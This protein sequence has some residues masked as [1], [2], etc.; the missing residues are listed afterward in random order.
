MHFAKVAGY[1]EIV[2]VAKMKSTRIFTSAWIC[3]LLA[4]SQTTTAFVQAQPVTGKDKDNEWHVLHASARRTNPIEKCMAEA[5]TITSK[6]WLWYTVM[7]SRNPILTKS[8]TASIL[9]SISDI[10]CQKLE[11]SS[12]VLVDKK[13]EA[14][15]SS[16]TTRIEKS[17]KKH[18]WKRTLDVA[19]VGL[20]WTGPATHAW[21]ATLERIV[22]TRHPI[23]GLA[24]RISLDAVIFAPI[25]GAY[26][27]KSL[28]HTFCCF[29][30][31]REL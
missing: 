31:F 1:F 24:A 13:Q 2:L 15:L 30:I 22:T 25:A 16:S 20:L 18:D 5:A 4:Q 10:V 17:R 12:I 3:C 26:L 14:S 11:Q 21:Y 6:P 23:L 27:T 9:L 29:E 7:L 28:L 19:I 8:I